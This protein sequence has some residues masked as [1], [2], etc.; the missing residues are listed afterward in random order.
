M[1]VEVYCGEYLFHEDTEQE[2]EAEG[3]TRDPKA[4][5]A[6]RQQLAEGNLSPGSASDTSN[7]DDASSSTPQ[8]FLYNPVHDLESLW[9]IALYF[10]MNKETALS[11]QTPHHRDSAKTRSQA[12]VYAK[13]TEGQREF[14]RSLFFGPEARDL[15][16]RSSGNTRFDQHLRALPSHLSTISSALIKLRKALCNQYKKIE[17]PEF[18]IDKTACGSLY[19][20][21]MDTFK[22]IVQSLAE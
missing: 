18:V 5:I 20:L 9:W 21:F 4:I 3:D 15:A 7:S 10:I 8:D 6:L 17:K 16:M 2:A 19:G 1:A 14:A 12:P 13:L 11:P 22:K